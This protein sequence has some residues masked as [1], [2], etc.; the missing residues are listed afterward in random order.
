MPAIRVPVLLFALVLALVGVLNASAQALGTF[1][2]QQ[3]P[4]CNVVTFNVVQQ[5]AVYQLDGFD[6]QCG[7]AASR[8]AA[9]ASR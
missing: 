6:D 4:F 9:T 8:A 3:Q 1:R 7:G 5:G 2:W